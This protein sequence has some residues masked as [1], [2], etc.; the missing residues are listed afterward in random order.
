MVT[1]DAVGIVVADLSKNDEDVKQQS[2]QVISAY[3]WPKYNYD[4]TRKKFF[5]CVPPHPM[6]VFHPI[7]LDCAIR[8]PSLGT[9][10]S[11]GPCTVLPRRRLRCSVSVWRWCTSG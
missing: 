8:S 3:A 11:L 2:I 1:E 5:K 4:A 9:R 7:S 6:P 10:A